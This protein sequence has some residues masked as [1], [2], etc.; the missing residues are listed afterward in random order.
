MRCNTWALQAA[1]SVAPIH[2]HI[3]THLLLIYNLILEHLTGRQLTFSSSLTSFPCFLPCS[4]SISPY[5]VKTNVYIC[6][7]HTCNPDLPAFYFDLLIPYPALSHNETHL[8]LYWQSRPSGLLLWFTHTSLPAGIQY[9]EPVY[10][11][12]G[13]C[14]PCVV[15]SMSTWQKWGV[16]PSPSAFVNCILARLTLHN[17]N[18]YVELR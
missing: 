13:L 4:V 11:P 8:H 2:T 3:N 17:G 9:A 12:E 16:W 14:L 10:P 5:Y 1:H 15:R 6:I 7:L 18:S